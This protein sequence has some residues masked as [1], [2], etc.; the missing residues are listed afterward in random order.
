MYFMIMTGTLEKT[1]LFLTGTAFFFL[2]SATDETRE[3]SFFDTLQTSYRKAYVECTGDSFMVDINYVL[4]WK[5]KLDEWTKSREYSDVLADYK[6]SVDSRGTISPCKLRAWKNL[7]KSEQDGREHGIVNTV[8]ENNDSIEALE[9]ITSHPASKFDF[10]DIPFGVSK[11][12]FIYLFKKKFPGEIIDKGD[13]LCVENLSWGARAFLTAFYFN[14]K[15]FFCKYEIESEGLPADSLNKSVRP[16]AEYLGA[17]F[18]RK[19]G[20]A[21]REN[22]VGFFDIKSNELSLLKKW[23]SAVQTAYIGLSVNKFKYYAKAII[24]DTKLLREYSSQD[25]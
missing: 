16:A 1:M 12:T 5:N 23:E 18:E 10:A 15:D 2:C 21:Q 14:K 9:A 24:S 17:M 4:M 13:L 11:N 22:R 3:T 7:H 25:K 6:K 19:L 8:L 20:S